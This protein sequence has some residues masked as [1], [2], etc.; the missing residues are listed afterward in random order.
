MLRQRDILFA[1][2]RLTV[3]MSCPHCQAGNAPRLRPETGE[4]T[5]TYVNEVRR[6]DGTI[7]KVKGAFAH[8]LC[9]NPPRTEP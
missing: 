3:P 9:T 1:W 8:T 6:P 4:W 2:N 7:V 5:H